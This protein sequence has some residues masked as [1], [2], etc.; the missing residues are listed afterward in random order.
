M[1]KRSRASLDK[2]V[3]RIEDK[4]RSPSFDAAVYLQTRSMHP[5]RASTLTKAMR[6][7]RIENGKRPKS[8]KDAIL[9][10]REIR[11]VEKTG[12]PYPADHTIRHAGG[13]LHM[14]EQLMWLFLN[15]DHVKTLGGR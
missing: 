10:P 7:R 5:G 6:A 11:R 14:H 8:L 3:S 13:S 12:E 9:T 4:D 2:L 15:I 1:T